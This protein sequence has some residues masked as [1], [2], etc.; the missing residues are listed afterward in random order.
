MR[1]PR[2]LASAATVGDGVTADFALGPG[3]SSP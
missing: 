1:L 2:Y 3:F